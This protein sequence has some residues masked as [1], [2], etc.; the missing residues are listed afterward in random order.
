MKIL[1]RC[2]GH[3][4][5]HFWIWVIFNNLT[6]LVLLYLQRIILPENCKAVARI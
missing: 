2:S 6:I 1:Q 4:P 3:S 5:K